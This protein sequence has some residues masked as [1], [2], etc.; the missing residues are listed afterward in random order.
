[1]HFTDTVTVRLANDCD[2][3]YEGRLEVYYHGMWGSV[4]GDG[5]DLND[6]Q[7]V[8]R[9]LGY[10]QAISARH[11]VFYGQTSDQNLL[12]NV[13]CVGTERII[14]E[15]SHGGWGIRNCY[16]NESAQAGVKCADPNGNIFP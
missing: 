15:C 16:Y 6:A 3:E 1:M 2:I 7:V 9:Q 12:D 5:W 11:E 14:S 10:G 8:C 4:C 13:S